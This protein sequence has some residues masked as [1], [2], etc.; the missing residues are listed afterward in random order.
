MGGRDCVD[1]RTLSKLEF[2]KIV[3][4]L[5]DNCSTK[6]GKEYAEKITP[7]TDKYIIESWL[8]E[9]SEAKDILR[10][11]PNFSLG[12]VRDI[13]NQLERSALGAILEPDDLL[14]I[15][16]T[17][18]AGRKTK[19]F[20]SNL[21]GSYPIVMKLGKELNLFKS[22]E[23]AVNSSITGEGEVADT[24]SDQ[25]YGLRR[26][27]A[28]YQ[29]KTKDKLDSLVRNSHTSKYL[30]DNIVTIR[31]GRYVVP[32]KQEYRSQVPGLIHDQ[33]AS[34][35]TLF[36]EPMAV[37]ELNNEIKK[38][39]ALEHEEIIKIL[40]EISQLV[41][42]FHH[43]LLSTLEILGKLDLIFA[44]ARLSMLMD[45]GCPRINSEA[46]IKLIRARHPLIKGDVVPI[47][48]DLGQNFDA[49]VIT[50]PNTGGK[51]VTLK[52]IGLLT[53]MALS[54]LHVPA[55]EG[56]EIGLFYQIYADIGDEQS[57]EQSLSTFSS[58]LVNIIRI[59]QN[60]K[61]NTLVLLDELGAGTDP[62]EGAALAMSIL[63]FLQ[64]N[65][66]KTVATTH[67][68]ELKAFAYSHPRIIN[69]S[70][71]FNV[72]TLQPT[73]RLLMG[74][75]GK[76]NAFEIARK[77][78]IKEEIVQRAGELL[79]QEEVQA[80][81][82]IANLEM[83]QRVSEQERDEAVALRAEVELI[84]KRLEEKEIELHNREIEIIQKAQQESLRIIKETR[85]QSEILYK[86]LKVTMQAEANKAQQKALTTAKEK[87]KRMED[88]YQSSVPE[89]KFGGIV[90][91]TVKVGQMVEIP[92]L[93]QKG[94]V[95]S[96]PNESGELYV[97][98]GIMKIMVKLDELRMPKD[99]DVKLNETRVG[100]LRAEKIRK[101]SSE[102]DLRGKMV[103]EA[104]EEIDKYIDD[105]FVAGLSSLRIIHG[106]GTGALRK[107]IT[108]HFKRHRQVK[109][110]RL[111]E[112]AEGGSGV[113]VVELNL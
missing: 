37:V 56:T 74:I 40:K 72:E 112:F 44:K 59:L 60:S 13:R 102:L 63:E 47:E 50:G 93:N 39:K 28:T 66:V 52:T 48:V 96:K 78:G 46:N 109:S 36:I 29:E 34:G 105:A 95:L 99:A 62:A 26:K 106:K 110:Y 22:I 90:P 30:Q 98:A 25:L 42:S 94:H 104:L 85:E 100:E 92:K 41:A 33:S 81:D 4:I 32:V 55:D 15:A 107:A 76:S 77:L 53:V 101:I 83:N 75:P 12:G 9:T 108:T 113:T 71:E 103:D 8:K 31:A 68:S 18:G 5:K 88:R 65:N 111:G 14:E 17:C 57:I 19:L 3:D 20:F 87:I 80:A 7:A 21:K 16:D 91:K 38:L 1:E 82:L 45:G 86:E 24:A 2:D 73:Y 23:T 97:Q 11:N 67:Y 27:I 10:L 84:K 43:D 51:T 61:A 70:V 54:G 6:I 89:K 58:H 79:S 69:A 64:I 35:A 49:M